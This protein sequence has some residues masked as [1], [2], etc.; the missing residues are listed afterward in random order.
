MDDPYA[1]AGDAADA[2]RGRFGIDRIDLAY[3]RHLLD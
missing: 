2:L 3:A 1:L